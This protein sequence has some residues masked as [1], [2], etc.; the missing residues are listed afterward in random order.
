[1]REYYK[2]AASRER[3]R[4]LRSTAGRIELAVNLRII[5][6]HLGRASRVLDL[7]GGTGRY[8]IPLAEDGHKVVLADLSPELLQVAREE[9]RR[10][11]GAANVVRVLEADARD[12]SRFRDCSFD[13]VLS[14]GPFY[15]LTRQEDR[16]RAA[17]EMARVLRPAGFAFVAYMP[18]TTLLRY[19]VALS[20]AAGRG[21]PGELR[22]ALQ[23]GVHVAREPGR[24]TEGYYPV[25]GEM[26]TLLLR[27]G[28]QTVR[29][30][31]SEGIAATLDEGAPDLW[32]EG[33]AFEE[34]LE[35]CMQ[36]AEEPTLE[37][38]TTHML[39][40]GR[41]LNRDA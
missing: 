32:S 23:A 33:D 13:A 2:G 35:V 28:I 20:A 7:G 25:P 22:D 27:A 11:P 14:M 39:L 10:S 3:E 15:H 36:T 9:I 40:V 12:L 41:K 29:S 8:A 18:R 1:M 4:L 31:A 26:Q 37:G 5:R 19:K 34:L 21:E 16:V 6:Q 24:F 30:V 17:G 38:A